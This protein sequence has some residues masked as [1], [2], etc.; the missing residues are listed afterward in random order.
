MLRKGANAAEAAIAVSAA[1]CVT[2]PCSTGLGGDMFCLFYDGKERKVSCVNGS[3]LSPTGLTLDLLKEVYPD[4]KGGV[5]EKDF[6]FSVHAVTVPGAARG[7]EDLLQRHG[8][9]KFTLA[10]LLEPAAI[11]AEE[12]FPVSPVTSHFWRNGMPQ[13]TKWVDEGTNVPLTVDGI[14]GPQPGDILK[15]PDMARVLR[16]LGRDGATKGFYEGR[17]GKSIIAAVQKHGGTMTAEDLKNHTSTFPQPISADYRNVRLWQVPPNGQGIAGL[18]ALKGLQ[19]IEEKGLSPRITPENLGSADTLHAMIEMMRLG[20]GDAR[21]YVTDLD[22]LP[23]TLDWLLETER[24]GKRAEEIFDRYQAK[25][26]GAPDKSS[27]TVS[28]QV[29]DRVGNAVSFVNSNFFGFGTGLV[30]DGCGFTLQNRGL[31]FSLNYDH[32]NVVAPRK[33]PYHT[34]IPGILTHSDTNELHSTLSNMGGNMQPQG[35]MQLTIDMIAGGLDPQAAIDQPRFCIADGTKEGHVDLEGG[36]EKEALEGLKS[37]GHKM[38]TDV[39][40]YERSVFGRA[41]IIK[42]DRTNGV[43]WAGSD[44]RADGCAM[45][46]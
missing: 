23:V 13:I 7:Y 32:P 6:M 33:R 1:L 16:D 34:I 18:I 29:V 44:G 15:N 12:G 8:S 45:G 26:A 25:V 14:R 11:L 39:V 30:P 31:G 10:S 35:H 41:Q 5:N 21:D 40:G 24:I 3:G 17:T 19:R 43:L 22:H 2:E 42:R 20:F 38:S 37:R 46:Y 36:V 27:C 4:Q 28:F 9:G